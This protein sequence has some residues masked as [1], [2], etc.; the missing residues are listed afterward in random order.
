MIPVG[1]AQADGEEP[2]DSIVIMSLSAFL[3]IL[4]KGA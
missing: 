3:A 2:E 4:K 1:I